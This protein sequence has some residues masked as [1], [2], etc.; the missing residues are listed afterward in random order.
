MSD[1]QKALEA[2][3]TIIEELTD[4]QFESLRFDIEEVSNFLRKET[5]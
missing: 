4:H 5:S 2:F 3:D 1:K